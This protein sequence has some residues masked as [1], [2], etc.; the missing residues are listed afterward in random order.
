[1][2]IHASLRTITAKI[3]SVAAEAVREWRFCHGDQLDVL[4][5]RPSRF[6]SSG[7]EGRTGRARAQAWAVPPTD[8][9]AVDDHQR[10][11][12]AGMS[13][14]IP[15][16]EQGSVVISPEHVRELRALLGEVRKQQYAPATCGHNNNAAVELA[17][18]LRA[19]LG[20][21]SPP[22]A[23]RRPDPALARPRLPA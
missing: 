18:Y 3:I 8:E 5:S 21:E 12:P 23:N 15:A 16:I 1:V 2:E 13:D 19:L 4:R 14:T 10:G 17:G 9:A 7:V 22:H 6:P 11:Y 20:P